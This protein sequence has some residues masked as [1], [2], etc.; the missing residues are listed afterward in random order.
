MVSLTLRLNA[1]LPT[2]VLLV[3]T[4]PGPTRQVRELS[5]LTISI[6]MVSRGTSSSASPST[7]QQAPTTTTAQSTSSC[8]GP[9]RCRRSLGVA[10]DSYP[11][12]SIEIRSRAYVQEGSRS[13]LLHVWFFIRREKQV[14][15]NSTYQIRSR[16]IGKRV[17]G[18]GIPY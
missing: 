7:S 3:P 11:R 15:E 16:L 1:S 18:S 17:G 9:L 13:P 6:L 4:E 8:T 10:I 12:D 5:T 2:V 14:R